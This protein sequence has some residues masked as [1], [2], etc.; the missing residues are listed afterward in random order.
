[1]IKIFCSSQWLKED[2]IDNISKMLRHKTVYVNNPNESDIIFFS[3]F[4]G[5]I[6]NNFTIPKILFNFEPSIYTNKCDL[7]FTFQDT[8]PINYCFPYF[9]SWQNLIID[10]KPID[11]STN[12]TRKECCY[13]YSNKV[14]HRHRLFN[15]IKNIFS[16]ECLGSDQPDNQYINISTKDRHDDGWVNRAI[17]KYK[18][19]KYVIAC[20]NSF[21]T[22]YITEKIVLPFIAG[23]IPIYCGT[24]DIFKWFNKN[25]F[26]YIPPEDID[27]AD[28]IIKEQIGKYDIMRQEYILNFNGNLELPYTYKYYTNLISNKL[29]NKKIVILC[30][31]CVKNET[32]FQKLE[33]VR[34]YNLIKELFPNIFVYRVLGDNKNKICNDTIPTIYVDYPDNYEYLISK[35]FKSIQIASQEHSNLDYLIKIDDDVE[36]N[37]IKLINLLHKN[38][39]EYGGYY[40][41]NNS[42]HTANCHIGKCE[43]DIYNKDII[44]PPYEACT[45]PIYILNKKSV[46]IVSAHKIPTPDIDIMY[47]DCYMGL[48]LI[49][50]NNI[51]QTIINNIY[52]NSLYEYLNNENVISWHNYNKMTYNDL[53]QMNLT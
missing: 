35:V 4:D 43:N 5:N 1:M 33:W 38:N 3:N 37:I 48:L 40:N 2:V 30:M 50:E 39:I 8:S 32:Q 23:A 41:S 19:Y 49:K 26:I 24:K 42:Y 34:K 17:E 18:N 16:I 28:T 21:G 53:D 7:Y 52:S 45:G 25:S 15:K 22:N 6:F 29:F 47:E 10:K 20:E 12:N 13:M 36:F 11:Y 44:L 51:K 14:H 31:S 46:D 9:L 27:N